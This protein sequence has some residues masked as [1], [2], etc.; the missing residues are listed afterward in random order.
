MYMLYD[1]CF[2]CLLQHDYLEAVTNAYMMSGV[3]VTESKGRMVLPVCCLKESMRSFLDCFTALNSWR[4][5]P[6]L[7]REKKTV[8]VCLSPP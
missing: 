5:F 3:L 8:I 6:S 4:P 1:E 7:E 2:R